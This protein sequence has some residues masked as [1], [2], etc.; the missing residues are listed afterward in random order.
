MSSDALGE[1]SSTY[2]AIMRER[3][4]DK[5]VII[6][7]ASSGIGRDTAVRFASEGAR[8]VLAARSQ[9]GLE[10]TARM[11]GGRE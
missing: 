1:G 3:F 8:V 6:T 4:Q 10:E 2:F 11:L 9:E 5:V 7:G